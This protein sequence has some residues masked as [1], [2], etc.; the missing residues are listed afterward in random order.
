MRN[1]IAQLQWLGFVL[2]EATFF[3]GLVARLLAAFIV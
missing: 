2:T 3:Y 1:E